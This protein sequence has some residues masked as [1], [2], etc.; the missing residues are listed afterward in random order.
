MRLIDLTVPIHTGM[1]VY[2][3]DP[4]VLLEPALRVATDGVNVLRVHL[5]SQTGTHVDAPAHL[6]DDLPTLD[7][8]PLHRFT[9]PALV[10]DARSAGPHGAL[11]PEY[12]DRPVHP[13]A[14]VL[15]ATGWSAHW[16][17]DAYH[18]HPSLTPAAAE[19]LVAAGIR[20]IGIDAPS[21]DAPDAHSLP[22]HRILCGAH[23][24]IA[25]NLTGLDQLLDAQ[26]AGEPIEVTLFPLPLTGA[27][28]AP[29]R[30]VA[31]VGNP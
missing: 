10:V 4:E 21:I 9:G 13:G 26:L 23:A 8:L 27:D 28:G 31:R 14:V 6:G 12:F 11:G 5:G 7:E 15:I 29:V 3:G 22:A 1:P 30:A 2:P 18:L 17:T 24:V 25:E 20:T 16:G 19:A